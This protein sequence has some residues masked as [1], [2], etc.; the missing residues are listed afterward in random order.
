MDTET[1]ARLAD[2]LK[3]RNYLMHHFFPTHN[4]ALHSTDGRAGMV[5]ELA[6]IQLSLTVGRVILGALTGVLLKVAGVDEAAMAKQVEAFVAKGRR[7][8]LM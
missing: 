7:L 1:D 2:A 3:R 8:D 5:E 6:D 4:F